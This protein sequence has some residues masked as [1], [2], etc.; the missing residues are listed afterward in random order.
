MPQKDLDELKLQ[1][2]GVE[3]VEFGLRIGPAGLEARHD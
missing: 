3:L 2:F 1:A